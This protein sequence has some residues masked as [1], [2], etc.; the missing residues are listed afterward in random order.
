MPQTSAPPA[1]PPPS[2]DPVKST[3][4]RAGQSGNPQGK[5]LGGYDLMAKLGEGGMA[6]VFRANRK[7]DGQVV[8][9]KVLRGSLA[10]QPDAVKDFLI[11]AKAASA[12]K[13]PYLPEFFDAGE[14]DGHHFIAMELISGATLQ[15]VIEK[16]G[17]IPENGALTIAKYVTE[18]LCFAWQRKVI[19]R[20][21]KPENLMV[22]PDLSLKLMDMGLAKAAGDN[23]ATAGEGGGIIGTPMYASPEQIRGQKDLDCRSDI[24]S[25]GLTIY[26]AVTGELPYDATT[27][28]MVMAKQLNEELP[29]PRQKNSDLS[30]NL[31]MMIKK[32]TEKDRDRRYQTPEDLMAAIENCRQ[33]LIDRQANPTPEEKPKKKGLFKR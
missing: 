5:E 26:H 18:I 10:S 19:H 24:Y 33:R 2:P 8:A 12:L 9:L 16:Q 20:D 1:P 14:A 3:P 32:M 23:K 11:E 7:S 27:S 6:R 31:T 15:K 28:A 22:Q 17:E 21:I 4:T 13:H 29:D 25:L 30:L